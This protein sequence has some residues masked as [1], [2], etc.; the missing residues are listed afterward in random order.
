MKINIYSPT[1]HRLDNTREFIASLKQSVA[2]SKYD[3]KAFIA[4][5]NSPIEMKE[6]LMG[7]NDEHT[8]VHLFEKNY[9]KGHAI[10][11][12]HNNVRKS[13]VVLSIDSDIIC[14]NGTNW[15][16]RMANIVRSCE[17]IGIVSARFQ[18]GVAHSYAS[19]KKK[20]TICGSKLIY[21][22]STIGGACIMLRTGMWN[23]VGGYSAPDI[24]AGDDG[25]LIHQVYNRQ[26]KKVVVCMDVELYHLDEDD[27]DYRAWKLSRMRNKKSHTKK[28]N[29]GYYENLR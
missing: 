29:T 10:N 19:L 1:Y 21:G 6:Y 5:N 16:D 18:E 15:I 7:Q 20:M 28:P 27:D 26:K 11:T 3:V 9:G 23:K 22:S 13:D 25:T 14:L 12:L 17:D 2:R 4:D 8:Q 24:Y